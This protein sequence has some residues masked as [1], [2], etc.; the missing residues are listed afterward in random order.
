MKKPGICLVELL[1]YIFIMCTFCNTSFILCRSIIE[2]EKNMTLSKSVMQCRDFIIIGKNICR[3]K[4]KSGYIIF[5]SDTR[6]M[7][8]YIGVHCEKKLQILDDVEIRKITFELSRINIDNTGYIKNAGSIYFVRGKEEKKL[9]V[10]V[11]TNY[12]NEE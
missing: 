5:D 6:Q 3:E 12:V 4:C 8:F 7:K 10:G 1:V 9:S 11:Y 2:S